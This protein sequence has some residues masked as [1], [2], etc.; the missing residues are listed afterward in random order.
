VEICFHTG[1]APG[2]LSSFGTISANMLLLITADNERW[3]SHT[4]SAVIRR[5]GSRR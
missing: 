1:A 5:Y 2:S 4:P 3:F